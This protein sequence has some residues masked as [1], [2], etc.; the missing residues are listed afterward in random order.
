MRSLGESGGSLGG[1]AGM[2]GGGEEDDVGKEETTSSGSKGRGDLGTD[3]E[4]GMVVVVE[5][6]KDEVDDFGRHW[7]GVWS[8]QAEKQ[9]GR[10]RVVEDDEERSAR[11]LA[12]WRRRGVRISQVVLLFGELA[13]GCGWWTLLTMS[14][15]FDGHR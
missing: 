8:V 13:G 6:G 1:R 9:N 11:T 14:R 7:V 4:G 10:E 12:R 2:A 3:A 5:K 15:D